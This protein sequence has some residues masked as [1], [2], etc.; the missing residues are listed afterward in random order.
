VDLKTGAHEIQLAGE[1]VQLG[2]AVRDI[3]SPRV[4][5]DWDR[6][7][8]Q[9]QAK[10]RLRLSRP[11]KGAVSLV[12]TVVPVGIKMTYAGFP[13]PLRE[14]H[15]EIDFTDHGFTVK[16][17][18][19]RSGAE[20]RI[21][22]DGAAD[23]YESD[24]G[25]SFR[26][27]VRSLTLDD[28]LRAA[29][30]PTAQQVWDEFS[31]RGTVDAVGRAEKA[32]GAG[33]PLRN[34]MDVTFK[35]ASFRYAKFPI[36]M[37]AV[38]GEIHVDGDTVV[39]KTLDGRHVNA[40]K[41][42]DGKEDVAEIHASGILLNLGTD[43]EIDLY[44]RGQNLAFD[45]LLKQALVPKLKTLW[46]EFLP[47][48]AFDFDWH[49]TKAPSKD[50]EHR[51][52]ITARN[53]RVIY[54]ITPLPVSG[55]TGEVNISPG[56]FELHNLKGALDHGTVDCNG[57]VTDDAQG[58][59]VDLKF[60][61]HDGRI[62]DRFKNAMPPAVAAVLNSLKFSGEA[63][64]HFAMTMRDPPGKTRQTNYAL[65]LNV[66]KG[67]I[68][69]KVRVDE[70]EGAVVLAGDFRN[71]GPEASGSLHFRQAR[72][73]GKKV[74]DVTGRYLVQ[75]NSVTFSTLRGRTYGGD[76]SGT[77]SMNTETTSYEGEFTVDRLELRDF[78]RDTKKYSDRNLSGKVELSIRMSGLGSDSN[79]MKGF[80]SMII[81]E[82]QLMEVPGIV[83]FMSGSW[84]GRFKA[85]RV[86]YV[87]REGKFRVEG[88]NVLAM[89]GGDGG[90]VYGQGWVDFDTNYSFKVTSDTAPL[91][92][93]DFWLF[94]IP[95]KLFDLAKSPFK[96]R[97]RG[98]LSTDEAET[99]TDPEKIK[100]P[101]E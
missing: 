87:I 53:A 52:T 14:V 29:M 43:P 99:I 10:V 90:A 39:V 65:W 93:I 23:G 33:Q 59:V 63:D 19:G 79:T 54:K 66:S 72:L 25:Y 100:D 56:R 81:T 34:P 37:E 94:K 98:R 101:D 38:K 26:I 76:I 92:G 61:V 4:H 44:L 5:R 27:E 85:C 42:T 86:D 30:G 35:N 62:D 91:F 24:S 6:Y 70:I 60:D 40:E 88:S 45:I 22:F 95:S 1:D 7:R 74:T 78:V 15:G 82:G 55:I 2:P 18:T 12:A 84:G 75:G 32:H 67:V 8:P 49:L 58:F 21:W 71:G 73:M 13:L 20:G 17:L 97:V 80:G 11:E 3:L 46:D 57:V 31:P 51:G 41:R 96:K 16:H 69:A 89:E 9:G 68:D 77:L 47:S 36:D 50:E 48:G 83:S 28:T 64:Y